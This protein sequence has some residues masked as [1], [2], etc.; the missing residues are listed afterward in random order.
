VPENKFTFYINAE[1]II[2]ILVAGIAVASNLLRAALDEGL[3]Q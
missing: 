3:S 1:L 2:I